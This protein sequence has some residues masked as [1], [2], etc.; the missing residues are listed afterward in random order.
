MIDNTVVE[1]TNERKFLC[2]VY[3]TLS[4]NENTENHTNGN[5]IIEA[6]DYKNFFYMNGL[7]FNL[8]NIN[9]YFNNSFHI[10]YKMYIDELM[11]LEYV[12]KYINAYT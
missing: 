5:L 11:L 7:D 1:D 8:E 4:R 3:T 12:P 2:T 9:Q 6:F 10:N